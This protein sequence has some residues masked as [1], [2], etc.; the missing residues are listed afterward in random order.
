MAR[1]MLLV[2][3]LAPPISQD[4]SYM[5]ACRSSCKRTAPCS[6]QCTTG[7]NSTCPYDACQRTAANA[8]APYASRCP[9]RWRPSLAPCTTTLP[10]PGCRCCT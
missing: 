3:L 6:T 1:D 7:S 9:R 5:L 4:E 2:A 10:S 8:M